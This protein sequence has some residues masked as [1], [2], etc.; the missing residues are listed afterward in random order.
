[1]TPRP[2]SPEER[3]IA[4]YLAGG[5]LH[6]ALQLKSHVFDD[7]ESEHDDDVL[8]IKLPK[9][10]LMSLSKH[11]E[12][13]DNMKS[14]P[15]LGNL[16]HLLSKPMQIGAGGFA[17]FQH[18]S[19][20]YE[21][22]EHAHLKKE[23]AKAEK[24]YLDAL[25]QVKQSSDTSTPNV[26]SF[27]RGIVAMATSSLEDIEKEAKDDM[28]DGSFKRMVKDNVLT[29]AYNNTPFLKPTV[30]TT[31][32]LATGSTLASALTV[33]LLKQKMDKAKSGGGTPSRIEIE[34]V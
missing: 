29:P 14:H 30:D 18:S 8:K 5:G 3:M 22:M 11:S 9:E 24:E 12:E 2:L 10:K 4:S 13:H 15:L 17:G 23:L 6:S 27:V 28:A 33:Y 31:K 34:P 21:D 25:G 20:M 32:A 16:G 1:M 19:K 7:D 26:D